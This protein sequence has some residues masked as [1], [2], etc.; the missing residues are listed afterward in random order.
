MTP[1][2]LITTS[3]L[4]SRLGE[5]TDYTNKCL[6]RVDSKPVISHIIESYPDDCEF[7]ITL[8]HYGNLVKDYILLVYPD[9]KV[10]FVEIDNFSDK[11]SSLGYS[12]L[13]ARSFL[14][15]PFVFHASD[16]ILVE[17]FYNVENTY[18]D[19]GRNNRTKLTYYTRILK[20]SQK[21]L[22]ENE[23]V[24]KAIFVLNTNKKEWRGERTLYDNDIFDTIKS[25]TPD[26][27]GCTP[28]GT[29]TI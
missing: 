5:K 28:V 27:S 15:C 11:G 24:D 6:I 10:T 18:P 13:Q 3:G 1:K 17:N 29:I 16:T 23:N 19:S 8:G 14:Q 22:D 4:G 7:V 12:L 26:F 25:D 20:R 2:V 21:V 9:K